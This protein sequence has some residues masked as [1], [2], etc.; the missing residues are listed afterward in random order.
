MKEEIC[1]YVYGA[2]FCALMEKGRGIRPIAVGL[3]LRRLTWKLACC[4]VNKEI[5]EY[6][7]PV[8]LGTEQG[9]DAAVHATRTFVLHSNGF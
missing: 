7:Y 8:Q 1:E 9:C 6:L 4:H 5:G 3:S 2:S